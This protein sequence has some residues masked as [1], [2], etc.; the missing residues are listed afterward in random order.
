M[1]ENNRSELQRLDSERKQ[2][3]LVMLKGFV[4]T[5]VQFQPISFS[6][7]SCIWPTLVFVLD[8]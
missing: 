7:F 6:M 8:G 2:D 5:Q 4:A 1:Q 3:F